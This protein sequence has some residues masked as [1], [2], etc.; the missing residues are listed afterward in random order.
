MDKTA[1]DSAD[2]GSSS[3]G[4]PRNAELPQPNLSQVVGILEDLYPLQYSESWD[5]P[6]LIVGDLSTGINKVMFAV[7]PTM[8]VVDEAIRQHANLLITHHPL[9]FK[10]VH[11]VSGLGFRG[12]IVNALIRNHCALWVGH[13]NADVAYHGVAQSAADRFG[14][15]DQHPLIPADIQQHG[16][17][18]GL[19]RVGRLPKPQ[20]LREFAASIAKVLP[21]TTS[22][23]Q[24]CGELD[25]LV[26][27]IAV[28]PGSGDSCFDEVRASDADVYV[29]SDLRHHPVTD[30]YQQS[31]Y[32]YMLAASGYAG[33]RGQHDAPYPAFINTPHSAIERL[34]LDYAATDLKDALRRRQLHAVETRVS[35]L[36]TDPWNLRI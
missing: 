5:A 23:I 18:V 34:W 12:G 4:K 29:T 6:G 17:D 27:R 24:V 21:K 13:T 26:R 28:L 30:A 36:N 32:E 1:S 22:G 3:S 8:D 16:H 10:A 25:G 9:L 20:T 2:T 31:R 11:Q 33:E 14:L 7:D 35:T 19:G 15:L